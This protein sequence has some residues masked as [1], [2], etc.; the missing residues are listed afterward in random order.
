VKSGAPRVVAILGVTGRLGPA[1]ARALAPTMTVRGLSRRDPL[2]DEAVPEG[3]RLVRAE[4]R[5]ADAL[6]AV[7]DGADAVVDLLC[8][9][10]SDA[11]A[12]LGA[13]A[14]AERPPRHLVFASS[15]AVNFA[16]D[17]G[18]RAR[19]EAQDGRQKTPVVRTP[20]QNAPCWRAS[21]STMACH[22][23]SSLGIG[24]RGWSEEVIV[25]SG[26][27]LAYPDTRPA[28]RAGRSGSCAPVAGAGG[29]DATPLARW[30]MPVQQ[31]RPCRAR[32]AAAD[33]TRAAARRHPGHRGSAT[34]RSA[35][36][37]ARM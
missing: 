8:L 7:I 37:S 3:V 14:R 19:R 34:D 27:A 31:P 17:P 15:I 35:R 2:A 16:G 13:V 6:A 23:W 26:L 18:G 28:R 24:A 29:R 9:S 25:G 22:F 5:D 10:A 33:R 21:R 11:D 12:L 36:G 32:A 30:P 1:V 4:R 20:Y